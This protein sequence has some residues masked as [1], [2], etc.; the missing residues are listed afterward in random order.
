MAKFCKI[1]SDR[2]RVKRNEW[3][4]TTV[5]APDALYLA[6]AGKV[7]M[8]GSADWVVAGLIEQTAAD[9]PPAARIVLTD[10]SSLPTEVRWDPEWPFYQKGGP[11]LVIPRAAVRSLRL[12]PWYSSWLEIETDGP[13]FHVIVGL[14]ARARTRRFFAEH[15]WALRS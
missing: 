10:L 3:F 4:A 14:L 6:V 7:T 9:R 11:V 2:I 8:F 15:G 13:C 5:G 1:G 12:G